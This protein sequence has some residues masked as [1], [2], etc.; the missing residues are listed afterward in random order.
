[1]FNPSVALH[2]KKLGIEAVKGEFYVK[3]LSWALNKYSQ[4]QYF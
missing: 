3:G 2:L 1:M 4:L